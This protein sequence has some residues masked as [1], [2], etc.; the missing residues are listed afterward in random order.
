MERDEEG[1]WCYPL[2]Y[3]KNKRQNTYT[4]K[5]HTITQSWLALIHVF[6]FVIYFESVNHS[7][8]R[9]RESQQ[10]FNRENHW[11]LLSWKHRSN[12]S[13]FL[14][15]KMNVVLWGLLERHKNWYNSLIKHK[16]MYKETTKCFWLISWFRD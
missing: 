7:L 13:Q 11:P 10:T 14:N 9:Q 8:P 6:N 12:L 5:N 2:V 4:Q 16:G 3:R 15:M 1:T